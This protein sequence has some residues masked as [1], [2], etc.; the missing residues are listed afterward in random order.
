MEA[1]RCRRRPGRDHAVR[2]ERRRVALCRLLLSHP[3]LLLL[4]EPPTTWTPSRWRGW[5]SSWPTTR[6]RSW[7]SPTTAT[8]STTSPSGSWSWT[9]AGAAL[10]RQLLGLAGAEAAAARPGGEEASALRRTIERKLEWVRMSPR[11]PGQ[12]QGTSHPL[13]TARGPGRADGEPPLPA[14][15]VDPVH[16]APR[17]QGHRG[18][19]HLKAYD[20]RVLIRDLSFDIPPAGIV[21]SSARTAP[22]RRPC[23]G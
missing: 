3:D 20:G 21:G 16:P 6:A 2:G 10:P 9:A 12:G 23:S 19:Q 15:F 8:S 17:R 18:E 13:R 7:R 1:L 14:H 11:P 22:A 5:R 4:D